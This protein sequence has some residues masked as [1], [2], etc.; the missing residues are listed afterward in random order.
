[1]EVCPPF[2][3][4]ALGLQGPASVFEALETLVHLSR[5]QFPCRAA[6]SEARRGRGTLRSGFSGCHQPPP[7]CLDTHVREAAL[8]GV[9]VQTSGG[10]F[11]VRQQCLRPASTSQRGA[12]RVLLATGLLVST[13]HPVSALG[14][15]A[16]KH[17]TSNQRETPSDQPILASSACDFNSKTDHSPTTCLP[18]LLTLCYQNAPLQCDSTGVGVFCFPLWSRI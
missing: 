3:D 5:A 10:D 17:Q 8:S 12:R 4:S 18:V 14:D 2:S 13:V 7:Y 15:Y 11:T 9:G 6:E 16:R 1:M